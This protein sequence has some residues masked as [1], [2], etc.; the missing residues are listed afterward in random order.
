MQARSQLLQGL[1]QNQAF[2]AMGKDALP[3]LTAEGCKRAKP[4]RARAGAEAPLHTLSIPLSTISAVNGMM[5]RSSRTRLDLPWPAVQLLSEKIAYTKIYPKQ[6]TYTNT[7]VC[8]N[9]SR[10]LFH[11]KPL[12]AAMLAV[13][14][15]HWLL[16]QFMQTPLSTCVKLAGAHHAS[17]VPSY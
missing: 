15:L 7:H 17:C 13:T 4:M 14:S 3:A 6:C 8:T 1:A 2:K 12:P 9:I 16:L 5:R 11:L 10:T